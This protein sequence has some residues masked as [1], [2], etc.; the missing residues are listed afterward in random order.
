MSKGRSM[1]IET[2][3]LT[4]EVSKCKFPW[5]TVPP[6]DRDPKSVVV[7]SPDMDFWVSLQLALE[8]NYQIM[9]TTNAEMLMTLVK[10][11]NPNLVIIRAVPSQKVRELLMLMKGALPKLRIMFFVSS[12][13]LDHAAFSSLQS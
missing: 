12:Q 4:V 3:D 5:P 9:T 11:F 6:S 10:T 8:D 13:K 2:H 1:N 7:Y